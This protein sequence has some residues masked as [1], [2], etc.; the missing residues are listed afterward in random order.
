[1]FA[2]FLKQRLGGNESFENKQKF[3]YEELKTSKDGILRHGGTSLMLSINRSSILNS[4]SLL[5]IISFK[6]L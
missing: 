2:L 6:K 1:M 4:V 5:S 3:F